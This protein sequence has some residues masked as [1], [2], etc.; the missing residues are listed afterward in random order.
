MKYRVECLSPVLVGDGSSLSPIDYMVWKDQVNVL[1]QQRIFKLL[2]K[3]PRLDGYLN[4]VRKAEKLDFGSWGGFAQ[5]FAGRRIPFEHASSTAHWERLRAEH[6]HIP[7]FARNHQG[8]YLPAS[9]LRGALRTALVAANLEEAGMEALQAVFA[10]ERP[11]R[12]GDAVEQKA[13]RAQGSRSGLDVLKTLTLSDSASVA[14]ESFR[15]YLARTSTLIESKPPAKP[16][17][18][19]KRIPGGSVEAKRVDEATAT[20]VEMAPPGTAFEGSWGE[21]SNYQREEVRKSLG[22]KSVFS[23]AALLEAANR[24]TGIV[25]EQHWRYAEATGLE[26]LAQGLAAVQARLDAVR[27]SGSACV[28]AVGWGAGLIPK[29]AWPRVDDEGFRRILSANSPFS[30]A[31]R[32]GLPFPKTRKIVFQENRPAALP[33]WVLL[34]VA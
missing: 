24:Y 22:W 11:W 12:A 1:D 20:F 17:L 27:E 5:N 21:R 23:T 6:C 15:V 28:L 33:G 13:F 18:G 30:R 2:A 9:A 7:T 25:L 10:G 19:W 26:H 31:I 4:Q 14:S 32:T 3:G 8:A 29:L 16:S 34:E